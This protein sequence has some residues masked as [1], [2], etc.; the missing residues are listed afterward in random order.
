MFCVR[1]NWVY[2]F[3]HSTYTRKKRK[4]IR[5]QQD[6]RAANRKGQERIEGGQVEHAGKKGR[7]NTNH[8]RKAGGKTKILCRK[9][10]S[11][12]K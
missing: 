11:G 3:G 9:G 7:D 2:N 8:A 5:A 6:E 1:S 12:D 4:R 10:R